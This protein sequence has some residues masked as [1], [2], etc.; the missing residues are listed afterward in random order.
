MLVLLFGK[1][2]ICCYDL[3]LSNCKQ[4][5]IYRDFLILPPRDHISYYNK[6]SLTNVS[7]FGFCYYKIINMKTAPLRGN[8]NAQHVTGH[9][10]QCNTV[11][12]MP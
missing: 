8:T 3:L 1:L 5:E 10:F 2:S 12:E 6:N 4:G 11:S 7:Y 9:R